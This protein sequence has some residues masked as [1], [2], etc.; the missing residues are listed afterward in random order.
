MYGVPVQVD[1]VGYLST[2]LGEKKG[3]QEGRWQYV[4]SYLCIHT[5]R[6]DK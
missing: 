1:Y 2:E 4:S 3:V 5:Q 6:E